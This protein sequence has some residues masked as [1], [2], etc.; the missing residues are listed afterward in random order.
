M[1]LP[2]TPALAAFHA[3]WLA[4]HAPTAP[5]EL[6]RLLHD[7]TAKGLPPDPASLRTLAAAALARRSGVDTGLS[8]STSNGDVQVSNLA[9]PADR[10]LL[11]EEITDLLEALRGHHDLFRLSSSAPRSSSSSHTATE[12]TSLVAATALSAAALGALQLAVHKART[13]LL[14]LA[15]LESLGLLPAR[16]LNSS[17]APPLPHQAAV[18]L[19]RAWLLLATCCYPKLAPSA[20]RPPN[21]GVIGRDKAPAVAAMH[22]KGLCVLEALLVQQGSALLSPAASNTA[23]TVSNALRRLLH[24]L[25]HRLLSF[26]ESTEQH[27]YLSP[28]ARGLLNHTLLLPPS[29]PSTDEQQ[30]QRQRKWERMVV[31]AHLSEARRASATQRPRLAEQHLAKAVACL[32]R[33]DRCLCP[34]LL[35]GEEEGI[36]GEAGLEGGGGEA[37]A[38]PVDASD[39]GQARLAHYVQVG[40]VDRSDG[41]G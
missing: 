31:Y 11:L 7:A 30:Q 19:N 36:V 18:A 35:V 34:P 13:A 1:H 37:D 38:R 21:S 39:L 22:G 25:P 17:A 15:H 32:K 28:W 9:E 3:S 41:W 27:R 40:V 8:F 6:T 10:G 16:F 29:S 5:L 20:P 14:L 4:Q 2:R 24:A 26:L 12:S 23:A 33:W